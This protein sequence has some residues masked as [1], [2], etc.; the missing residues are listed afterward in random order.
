MTFVS[1]AQN[2]EDVILWRALGHIHDGLYIDIG[3]QD[4][5]VDSVSLPFYQQGWRGVHIE[6]T[7]QYSNKLRL[8]RPDELV[9][10]VALGQEEGILAFYEIPDTGLSTINAA[11]AEQ[12][13]AQ[14]FDQR[15]TVVPVMTLD[16]VLTSLGKREVHWLKVDVEG[17]EKDVLMGWRSSP[18]RPWVVAIEATLP[19]STSTTHHE[20]EDLIFQKG[21]T[22]VYFDGLNRFYVSDAHPALR[23]KFNAP[24]NVFDNFVL[25]ANHYL[26]GQAHVETKEARSEVLRTSNIVRH[27]ANTIRKLEDQFAEKNK[28]HIELMQT[29]DD[30]K[31]CIASLNKQLHSAQKMHQELLRALTDIQTSTFWRATAPLRW[32]AIQLRLLLAQGPRARWSAVVQRAG[33]GAHGEQTTSLDDCTQAAQRTE[34]PSERERLV[35]DA[36]NAAIAIS[37]KKD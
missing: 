27:S 5:I 9:L 15:Q 36:L 30:L 22:F 35:L 8:A 32:C 24:P 29:C 13:R 17:A 28:T 1:Y 31:Q 37:K 23:E 26:C 19:M 11:I 21:Y 33:A 34:T 3:A 18:V 10:Q 12:H 7:L 20:W 6:P 16:T 2:F 14:G 25:T 4:P